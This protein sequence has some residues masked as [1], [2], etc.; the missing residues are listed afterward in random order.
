VVGEREVSLT[1]VESRLLYALAANIGRVMSTDTLLARGWSDAEI[2]DPAYVWVTMRRLRQKIEA[3]PDHPAYLET[4][5]G[6]GYRLN[7][8]PG[9]ADANGATPAVTNPGPPPDPS[10]DVSGTEEPPLIADE[11]TPPRGPARR[12]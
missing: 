9:E 5:R 7:R 3:D 8:A 12:A 4:I 10:S 1:P 11:G 6:I 2:P